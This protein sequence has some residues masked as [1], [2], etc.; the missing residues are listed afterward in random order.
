MWKETKLIQD[1]RLYH[2]TFC[3]YCLLVR[4]HLWWRGLKIPLANIY[5]NA[6]HY[7]DLDTFGGK[8]QVPCL[9]IDNQN[10][11]VRWLYESSEILNYIDARL[12]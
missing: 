4:I 9:R 6:D 10:G 8:P 5:T 12:V 2:S 11:D 3:Q 1:H 7:A